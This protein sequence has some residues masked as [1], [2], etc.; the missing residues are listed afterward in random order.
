M[1]ANSQRTSTVAGELKFA[2]EIHN[3]TSK[4]VYCGYLY[5]RTKDEVLTVLRSYLANQGLSDHE[6]LIRDWDLLKNLEP[7]FFDRPLV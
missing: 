4:T 7:F 2:C 6:I 5:A 3:S 1:S